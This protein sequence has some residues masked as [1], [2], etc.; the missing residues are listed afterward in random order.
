MDVKQYIMTNILDAGQESMIQVASELFMAFQNNQVF[1]ERLYKFLIEQTSLLPSQVFSYQG[2]QALVGIL[3]WALPFDPQNSLSVL[4]KTLFE[5]LHKK[6]QSLQT[7]PQIEYRTRHFAKSTDSTYAY[8]FDLYT[9]EATKKQS[10]SAE[11]SSSQ[12]PL[13][14]GKNLLTTMHMEVLPNETKTTKWFGSVDGP[15]VSDKNN[16]QT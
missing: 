7:E 5:D 9:F 6:I 16:N 3:K 4:T 12:V 15:K 8:P 11:G 1:L 14:K 2:Y 10:V 13:E